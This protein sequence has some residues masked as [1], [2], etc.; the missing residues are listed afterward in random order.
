M[1][2]LIARMNHETNTFSPVP[3]PAFGRRPDLRRRRLRREQGQAHRPPSST[4]PRRAGWSRRCRPRPTQRAGGRRRRELCD[5]IVAAARGRMRCCWI[6]MAPWR[7]DHRRRRGRPA[8]TAAPGRAGR[9]GGRGAG[10]ARQRHAEDG[11]QRRR[12]HQLQ[13]LSPRRH[14]RN[15]RARRPHLFDWLAGR[16]GAD[17][18]LPLMTHAAQRHGRG[19]DA[20]G[21]A[22]PPASW[23]SRAR[24]WACRC[25]PSR[26]PAPCLS[27]VAVGA[28]RPD[29]AA[30]R[31]V[32]AGRR[33]L[34]QPRRFLLP[35]SRWPIR[36]R[37]RPRAGRRRGQAGV[38]LDH[39][40]NCHVGRHLRHHGRADGGAGRGA[41]RHQAGLC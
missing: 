29:A 3:T 31:A 10:P 7:S 40:D 23:P 26:W 8:G 6:C 19:R 41:D 27:V 12:H 2:V 30:E 9:A 13:D 32:T 36:W 35:A 25:W 38:L 28:V 22:E 15:R 20:R 24:C 11:G 39:G 1:K 5:R 21:G 17:A 34:G 14:V 18:R 4:W 16:A 37:A 33:H